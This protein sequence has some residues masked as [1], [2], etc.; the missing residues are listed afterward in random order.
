MKTIKVAKITLTALYL[1][2]A[3]C[4]GIFGNYIILN[5]IAVGIA[6]GQLRDK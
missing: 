3:I 6:H 5:D 4:F 2:F 1:I